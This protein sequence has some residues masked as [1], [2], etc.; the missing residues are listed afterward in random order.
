MKTE[1]NIKYELLDNETA[2]SPE[3]LALLQL[4]RKTSAGAYAPYSNFLVGAAAMLNNGEIVT[5]TN[6]ENASYPVGICAERV[7]LSAAAVLHPNEPIARLAISYSNLNGLSNKPIS[8]CGI[9]RQSLLEYEDRMKQGFK[10]IMSGLTGKILIISSAAALLP[11]SFGSS[12]L[13]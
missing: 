10:I 12:D 7:L 9:C 2:L 13:A 4:A 1:L 8:P 11:F 6:Q 3:D 5:G